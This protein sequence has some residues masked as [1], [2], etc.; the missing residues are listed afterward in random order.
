MGAVVAGGSI[1]CRTYGY[2]YFRRLP[3]PLNDLKDDENSVQ[4]KR[5][6]EQCWH[7]DPKERITMRSLAFDFGII[8]QQ[9]SG[10]NK[11]VPWSEVT[12]QKPVT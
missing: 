7:K 11:E 2:V 6:I 4:M 8:Y 3:S 1:Y 10:K 9:I 5:L 12:L